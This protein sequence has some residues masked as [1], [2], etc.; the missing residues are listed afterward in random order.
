[1]LAL[2]RVIVGIGLT[3]KILVD[4]GFIK[5]ISRYWFSK[6]VLVD[7]GFANTLEV[8]TKR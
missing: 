2:Q 7:N 5:S 6:K 3:K 1:M 8:F 4:I